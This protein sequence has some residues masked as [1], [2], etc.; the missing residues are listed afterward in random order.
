MHLLSVTHIFHF[1]EK[2]NEQYYQT[3]I[4]DILFNNVIVEMWVN[5]DFILISTN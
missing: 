5:F 2:T 4:A 3:T 1:F